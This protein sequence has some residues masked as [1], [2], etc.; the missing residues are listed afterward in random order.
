MA[1]MGRFFLRV[2]F[3]NYQDLSRKVELA[4]PDGVMFGSPPLAERT[5]K[6][7]HD[8]RAALWS[9]GGQCF[10]CHVESQH[11][12]RVRNRCFLGRISRPWLKIP[13][14]TRWWR[15]T[16]LEKNLSGVLRPK[17]HVDHSSGCQVHKNGE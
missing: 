7:F 16:L 15:I 13:H 2:K 5:Q 11:L 10:P 6:E 4:S 3:L 12:G 9:T 17:D 14:L 8:Q 1:L